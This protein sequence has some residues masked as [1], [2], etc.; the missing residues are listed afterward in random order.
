MRTLECCN[1]IEVSAEEWVLEL[2]FVLDYFRPDLEKTPIWFGRSGD[3]YWA[4]KGGRIW[5]SLTNDYVVCQVSGVNIFEKDFE[6][7]VG[8]VLKGVS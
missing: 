4:F 7:I 1:G 6:S 8:Y 3:D 5:E 2:L